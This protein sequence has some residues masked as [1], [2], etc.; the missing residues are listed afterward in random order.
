MTT[1]STKQ[2]I[3]RPFYLL[4]INNKERLC[5]FLKKKKRKMGVWD[6]WDVWRPPLW[7]AGLWT[8]N[9]SRGWQTPQAS[10]LLNFF[11]PALYYLNTWN[12]LA[13]FQIHFFSAKMKWAVCVVILVT[14]FFFFVFFLVL[15]G[16]VEHYHYHYRNLQN[17]RHNCCYHHVIIVI[18]IDISLQNNPW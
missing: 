10:N 4:M 1:T 13:S 18:I 12:R 6:V 11:S 9:R 2:L 5:S 16:I 15:I 17:Q 8:E 3:E 7:P 14:V